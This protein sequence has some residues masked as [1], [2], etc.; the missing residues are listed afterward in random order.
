PPE[1]LHSH[2]PLGQSRPGLLQLRP[3]LRPPSGERLL[4]DRLTLLLF[5]PFLPLSFLIRPRDGLMHSHLQEN[6]V[7]YPRAKQGQHRQSADGNQ[8]RDRRVSPGPLD[9][10]LPLAGRTRPDRLAVQKATKIV[11][12]LL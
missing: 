1:L 9:R 10:P 5:G 4:L 8:R 2:P 12:Q 6:R 3:A 7:T 11:C